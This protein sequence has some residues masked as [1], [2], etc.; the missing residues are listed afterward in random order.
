[1]KTIEVWIDVPETGARVQVSNLG[2]LRVVGK[3]R[4]MGSRVCELHVN[5]AKGLVC[6]Y[7]SERL[8]WYVF[9]D[10][11]NHF[12]AREELMRMFPES[13]ADIDR[14]RDDDARA[15]KEKTWRDLQAKGIVS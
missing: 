3:K 5:E 8:G 13:L 1:M 9:F 6:D 15:L 12:F 2:H 14:S 10:R 4:R 7:K 11:V